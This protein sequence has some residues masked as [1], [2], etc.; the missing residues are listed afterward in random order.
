MTILSNER[1]A[2]T[3]S[4]DEVVLFAGNAAQ[5]PV[6]VTANHRLPV[7]AALTAEVKRME[8]EQ[9]ARHLE[10]ESKRSM[11]LRIITE[12]KNLCDE[13]S[14]IAAA[15][16][17]AEAELQRWSNR[18][19]EIELW[20][21]VNWERGCSDHEIEFR[22]GEFLASRLPKIIANYKA[23]LAALDKALAKFRSQHELPSE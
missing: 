21:A 1:P 20:I 15:L 13:Q 10:I 7:A 19:E 5:P 16:A 9:A 6:V 17:R 8:A 23:R 12:E 22:N 14:A 11:A 18:R 2:P 4:A 3:P